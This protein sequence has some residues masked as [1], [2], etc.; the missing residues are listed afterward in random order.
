[1][2]YIKG[3]MGALK[4]KLQETKP[5]RVDAFM[6]GAQTVVKNILAKFDEFEFY[7][8][9]SMNPDGMVLLKFWKDGATDPTFWIWKDGLVEEKV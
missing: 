5:E 8:G 6:K 1:M 3:Y 9:E 4:A 7:T 2:S